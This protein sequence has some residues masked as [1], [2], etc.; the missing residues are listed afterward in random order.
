MEADGIGSSSSL[1][2]DPFPG[3]SNIQS[4]IPVLRNGTKLNDQSITF[5]EE[6]NGVIAF[7]FKGGSGAPLL[8]ASNSF[9][10]F[11]TVQGTPSEVQDI[12]IS[13]RRL[14]NENVNIAQDV[15]SILN[16]FVTM[17]E[18]SVETLKKYL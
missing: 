7:R 15:K 6:T 12:E 16:D 13:G 3:T 4:Y 2:G 14:L 18:D 5:I 9:K 11:E 10:H 8:V 17:Q 1:G